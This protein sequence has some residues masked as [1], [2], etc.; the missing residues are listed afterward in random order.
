MLGRMARRAPRFH[1]DVAQGDFIPLADASVP[2]LEE[3]VARRV[4]VGA[5]PL[6]ELAAAADEV[7]VQVRFQSGHESKPETVGQLEVIVDV[8]ARIHRRCEPAA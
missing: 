4:D 6:G 5:G 8:A 3:R 1:G 2:V 7:G